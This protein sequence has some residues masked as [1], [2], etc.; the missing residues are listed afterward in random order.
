MAASSGASW[1]PVSAR[2]RR[3]NA[4]EALLTSGSASEAS[5]S[6]TP[7]CCATPRL[8]QPRDSKDSY[9]FEHEVSGPATHNAE[10]FCTMMAVKMLHCCPPPPAISTAC[11]SCSG[12]KL[13]RATKYSRAASPDEVVSAADLQ[14]GMCVTPQHHIRTRIV[15]KEA[16][17]RR[18]D[19]FE[20]ANVVHGAP[21]AQGHQLHSIVEGVVRAPL[22]HQVHCPSPAPN[23]MPASQR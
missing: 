13:A 23:L 2:W 22:Y 9:S 17:S 12:Q 20:A 3:R 14:S 10:F 18:T 21:V 15:G 4:S 1:R 16:R 11:S 6:S 7:S 8:L 5:S 19:L